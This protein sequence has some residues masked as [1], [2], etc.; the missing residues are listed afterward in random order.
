MNACTSAARPASS[1]SAYGRPETTTTTTG[2]PVA[3]SSASRSACTPGQPQVL[4]VAALAGGAAAEQPG[5]VADVGDAQ[6]GVPGGGDRGGE[7]GP[8]VALHRAALL[9]PDLDAGQLGPQ[10]VDRGR[11]LDAEPEPGVAGQH[12]V[13]EGV[14]AH[15]RARVGGARPDRGDPAQRRPVRAE[16]RQPVGGVEQHDRALGHLP[17]QRPVGRR[18]EVDAGVG[19]R[20]LRR[21]VRVEQPQLGLLPQQPA[22]G[23]VDQLGRDLAGADPLDQPL[24]VA[25][26]CPAARR[27]CR[28]RGPA[29]RPRRRRPRPGAWWPGTAPPSSRRPPCRRSPSRPAAPRSAATSRRR[30]ARRRR[31]S[32]SS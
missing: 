10:R 20:G 2:V 16:Q 24:A 21:P 5:Q 29:R 27:R 13:G 4:G 32:T 9:V 22:G 25:R 8:V 18:V 31:P 6:V 26:A 28:P 17:G 23:P 12:V 14:A 3:S 7:P 15:E 19:D 30:R 1:P 11:H